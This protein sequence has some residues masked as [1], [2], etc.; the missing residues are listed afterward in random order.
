ME[1]VLKRVFVLT[2]SVWLLSGSALL[3]SGCTA[4]EG[5]II[6][7]DEAPAPLAAPAAEEA[8]PPPPPPPPVEEEV[9]E[10]LEVSRYEEVPDESEEPRGAG[11]VGIASWY[12][13]KFHGRPTASGEI[14]DMYALTSAHRTLP[15][16]TIVRVTNVETNKEVKVKVNDRGPFVEGRIIDLSF[17]AFNEI[18]RVEK[19]TARVRVEAVGR[20]PGYERGFN[21]RDSGTG[22]YVVQVGAFTNK[23]NAERLKRGL[24]FKY[25]GAYMTEA[26][27]KGRTFHRVRAGK[28]E[29]REEAEDVAKR[30]GVEGY[31]SV[32]MR[33]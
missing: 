33:E 11:T 30:L 25:P 32:I 22:D 27:V 4:I 15:L 24:S 16:G 1:N 3:F 9:V 6:F 12:G 2:A 17:A 14:Y 8:P 13:K 23:E 7:E 5:L 20:D 18:E 31:S 10:E 28:F 26:L 21:V 29:T 19:G